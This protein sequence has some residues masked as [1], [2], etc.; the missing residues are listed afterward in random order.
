[1]KKQKGFTLI[2]ILIVVVIIALMATLVLPRMLAQPE[3]MV[4]GEAQN[5]LGMV[6]RTIVSAGLGSAVSP[7]MC[8]GTVASG[9]I[10]GS[11]RALAWTAAGFAAQSGNFNYSCTPF[12]AQVPAC[13]AAMV[14]LGTCPAE[15][16]LIPA[17]DGV[18][19]ATRAPGFPTS[20]G[21]I[22]LNL[23]SALWTCGAP[24]WPM[25]GAIQTSTAVNG[26]RT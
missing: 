8:S 18:C 2:E 14:A 7:A 20:G 22:N 15:A 13:T 21:T 23:N 11:A 25:G 10:A 3:R 26:C 9:C 4:I 5:V 17:I 6:R 1:M 12:Q 16:P 19:T 24:Y